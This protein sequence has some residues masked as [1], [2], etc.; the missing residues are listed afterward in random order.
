MELTA[1]HQE[2]E[3]VWCSRFIKFLCRYKKPEA[4]DL[5]SETLEAKMEFTQVMWKHHVILP[6]RNKWNL[7]SFSE[8]SW[9]LIRSVSK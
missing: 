6:I 1:Y 4:S 3:A 5:L 2:S 7:R 9:R 8:E